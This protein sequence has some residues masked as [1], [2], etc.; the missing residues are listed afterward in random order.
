MSAVFNNE[1]IS[2]EIP[3][4][5][6]FENCRNHFYEL[7]TILNIDKQED[8]QYIS[9][10]YDKDK[11]INVYGYF[12][13]AFERIRKK[14]FYLA[15]NEFKDLEKYSSVFEQFHEDAVVFKMAENNP[16]KLSNEE[17][18]KFIIK[19]EWTKVISILNY[20]FQVAAQKILGVQDISHN[21]INALQERN[22]ISVEEKSMLHNFRMCRNGLEHPNVERV[23]F[24]AD[25][26]RKW[27]QI[28]LKL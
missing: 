22:V 2:K 11:Y 26:L 8:Y 6:Q 28:I 3:F 27:K 14:Y 1:P 12:V 9:D 10:D 20:K 13:K 19:G 7:K 17:I 5:E 18:E 21:M 23:L 24:D 15:E 4:T 25:D 16:E